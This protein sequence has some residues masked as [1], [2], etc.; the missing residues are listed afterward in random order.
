MIIR[1]NMQLVHARSKPMV[2]NFSWVCHSPQLDTHTHTE[3]AETFSF[4]SNQ[5]EIKTLLSKCKHPRVPSYYRQVKKKVKCKSEHENLV[6]IIWLFHEAKCN[7]KLC[8]FLLW[9]V[10]LFAF[11][12]SGAF[13]TSSGIVIVAI[14]VMIQKRLRFRQCYQFSINS[15]LQRKSLEKHLLEE[16][17]LNSNRLN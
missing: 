13:W 16:Q 3:S 5:Y 9:D 7:I 15:I 10:I 11:S 1:V 6:W 14:S 17:K 8:L 4:L 12:E 2:W